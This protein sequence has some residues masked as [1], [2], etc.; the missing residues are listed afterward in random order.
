MVQA[1][2]KMAP[3]STK[4]LGLKKYDKRRGKAGRLRK[5]KP[6]IENALKIFY[7]ELDLPEFKEALTYN[8]DPK[9]QMLLY[10]IGNPKLRECSFAQLCKRCGLTIRDVADIWIDHQKSLGMMKAM[11]HVPQVMEDVAID[12]KSRTVV[13]VRCNGDGKLH[14]E[15]VNNMLH[16]VC[17]DCHGDGKIRIIG[18]KDSRNLLYESMGLRKG[19]QVNQN[20][21]INLG[22][23]PSMEDV[24]MDAEKAMDIQATAVDAEEVRSGEIRSSAEEETSTD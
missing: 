14:T 1:K 17:P 7:K 20:M 8:K 22:G 2:E 16:S 21:N 23:M 9:F 18:D 12:S 13:C 4:F 10:A 19:N 24:I 11:G 15:L 5:K 6:M 3:L